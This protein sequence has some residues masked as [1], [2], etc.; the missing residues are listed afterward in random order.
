MAN[1]FT[2]SDHTQV[3]HEAGIRKA[4]TI[5]KRLKIREITVVRRVK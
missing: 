5:A 3:F 1:F 4:K 2:K